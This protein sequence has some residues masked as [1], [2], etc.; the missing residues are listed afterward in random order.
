MVWLGGFCIIDYL[1][2]YFLLAFRCKDIF[3][4]VTLKAFIVVLRDV[5]SSPCHH[6]QDGGSTARESLDVAELESGH[7]IIFNVTTSARHTTHQIPHQITLTSHHSTTSQLMTKRIPLKDKSTCRYSR[8]GSH[9]RIFPGSIV[10]PVWYSVAKHRTCA[11]KNSSKLSM[12][13]SPANLFRYCVLCRRT[14]SRVP[15]RRSRE[16]DGSWRICKISYAK[17]G[18]LRLMLIGECMGPRHGGSSFVFAARG[19]LFGNLRKNVMAS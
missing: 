7:L 15:I 13:C 4:L 6:T 14:R 11:T 2:W 18:F 16:K 9:N 12:P 17:C 19:A 1:S 3:S 5:F 10:E 8:S